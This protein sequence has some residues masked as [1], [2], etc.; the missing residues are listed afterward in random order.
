MSVYDQW[1]EQNCDPPE[2]KP[3]REP[4]GMLPVREAKFVPPVET[5]PMSRA[6]FDTLCSTRYK[7]L[8]KSVLSV[9]NVQRVDAE[10]ILQDVLVRLAETPEKIDANKNPISWI[11]QAIRWET[12]TFFRDKRKESGMFE[13]LDQ[14]QDHETEKNHQGMSKRWKS[15]LPTVEMD[16]FTTEVNDALYELPPKV[17]ECYNLWLTGLTQEEIAQRQGVNRS[18]VQSRLKEAGDYLRKRFGREY[19]R[20]PE[21]G[22]SKLLD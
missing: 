13:S 16:T 1:D 19:N 10:D 21:S 6:D 22:D 4:T 14:I 17:S 11:R 15:M 2:D 3:E 7:D 8:L 9:R 18:T 20:R 12:Q 5:R